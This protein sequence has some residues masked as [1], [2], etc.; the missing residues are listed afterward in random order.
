[1]GI[2]DDEL[3]AGQPADRQVPQKRRPELLRLAGADV[4]AEYFPVALGRD[5]V[6]ALTLLG[7]AAAHCQPV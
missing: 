5:P 2:A 1:M 6:L 7:S 3:D 4:T